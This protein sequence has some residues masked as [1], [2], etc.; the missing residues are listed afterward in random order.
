MGCG[1]VLVAGSSK[2]GVYCEV[3]GSLCQCGP[4]SQSSLPQSEVAKPLRLG[5]HAKG[6]NQTYRMYIYMDSK[7]MTRRLL[8]AHADTTQPHG[9]FGLK[10]VA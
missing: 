3:I 4:G 6:S 1:V 5:M 7:V 9:A 2:S 10:L 8:R